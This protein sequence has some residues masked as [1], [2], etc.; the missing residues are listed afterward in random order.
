MA[1]ISAKPIKQEFGE[2]QMI[3]N[4][5]SA[6]Q[7]GFT[8]IELVV[9]IVILGILA[10]TALPKFVDMGKDARTA[11][12]NG[13]AGAI[14]SAAAMAYAQ[15]ALTGTATYPAATAIAAK[16]DLS[17]FTAGTDGVWQKDGGS[18]ATT[19]TVTYSAT[20]GTATVDSSG[21]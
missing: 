6:G 8:L 10:A 5:K 4:V 12:L 9:V 20:S 16:V 14:N 13:A 1:G 18:D 19:C 17:G 3:K 7:A 2:S 15:S 11:A 21:C